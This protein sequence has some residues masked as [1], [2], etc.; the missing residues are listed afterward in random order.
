MYVLCTLASSLT[1]DSNIHKY[2]KK[3]KKKKDLDIGGLRDKKWRKLHN[4][5]K[6]N[7]YFSTN[8]SPVIKR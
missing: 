8:D 3:K 2:K 5:N 1:E 6:Y 7:V 4:K